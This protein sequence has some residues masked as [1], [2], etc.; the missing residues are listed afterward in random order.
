M[1][2]II[3]RCII[4]C[5]VYIILLIK[6]YVS[7]T[8]SNDATT[9]DTEVPWNVSVT[10]LIP[11]V[12]VAVFTTGVIIIMLTLCVLIITK[13]CASKRAFDEDHNPQPIVYDDITQN[14][15][16]MEEN[17]AY[18]HLRLKNCH[19]VPIASW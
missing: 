4:A 13:K 8:D 14:E 5:H 9:N 2:G 12:V 15:I 18:G 17:T 6:L 3:D 7:V 10:I 19:P 1:G 11:L 16:L